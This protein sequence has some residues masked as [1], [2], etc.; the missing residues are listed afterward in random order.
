MECAPPILT[1]SRL[2][3]FLPSELE[4]L[5]IDNE[6]DVCWSFRDMP[7]TKP[8]RQRTMTSHHLPMTLQTL[9]LGEVTPRQATRWDRLVRDDS[10]TRV[11][12]RVF[13]P[14]GYENDKVG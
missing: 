1:S 8:K 3:P 13:D 10:M 14:E 2:V 11:R 5:G 12:F 4:I 7:R 6:P 9:W